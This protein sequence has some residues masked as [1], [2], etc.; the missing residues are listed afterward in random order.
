[1]CSSSLDLPARALRI[2][3]D[4]N[5]RSAWSHNS[6]RMGVLQG[7]EQAVS[8]RS[9]LTYRPRQRVSNAEETGRT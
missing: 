7:L 4:H 6:S 3:L 5:T 9:G 1:M 8:L 2:T